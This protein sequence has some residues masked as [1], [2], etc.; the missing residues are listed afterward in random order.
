MTSLPAAFLCK[1]QLLTQRFQFLLYYFHTT[2]VD[3]WI[4]KKLSFNLMMHEQTP[5]IFI[6]HPSG[7]VSHTDL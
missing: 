5:L 1:L 4:K 6:M 2:F 3:I 7:R